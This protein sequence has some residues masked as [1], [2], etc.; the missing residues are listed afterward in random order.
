VNPF[1]IT[2]PACLSVSGGRTSAYM[3]RQVLDAHAGRLPHDVHAVFANTGKEFPQTLDFVRDLTVH[4]GV[5]IRWLEYETAP[6]GEFAFVEVTHATAARNGEPFVKMVERERYMPNPVAR[7][8]TKNLKVR[9]M[10]RF[11]A[12]VLG[13]DGYTEVLGL[14]ADEPWR[15]AK[16]RGR[17]AAGEDLAVPLADAGVDAAEVGFFWKQQPFDL[18]LLPGESN[19]DLCYLKSAALLRR[20]IAEHPG[21]EK[22][23]ADLETT[24]GCTFRSDRPPYAQ[25]GRTA[26]A[27]VS[28][29]MVVD[30]SESE[31]CACTD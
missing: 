7:I 25:L 14:R 6:V 24:R 3:L 22:W 30:G 16:I 29:P 4:W 9:V 11:A 2:G 31:D 17:I 18:R 1:A 12:Q 10:Q 13:F 26:R 5:P 15:V 28:L 23:W 8:C 19:C 21:V 27:Q 20:I